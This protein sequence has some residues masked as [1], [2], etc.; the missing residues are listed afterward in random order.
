MVLRSFT[1]FPPGLS[2]RHQRRPLAGPQPISRSHSCSFVRGKTAQA[3]PKDQA[4]ATGVSDPKPE[5]DLTSPTG[6]CP[7]K[8]GAGSGGSC[9]SDFHR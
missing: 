2:G 8:A 6:I 1:W 3:L 7:I 5:M 9:H 4:Q